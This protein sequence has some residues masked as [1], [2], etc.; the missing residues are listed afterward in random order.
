MAFFEGTQETTHEIDYS[1]NC[2]ITLN[3]AGFARADEVI[4]RGHVGF[5]IVAK[6]T[7]PVVMRQCRS[8][9]HG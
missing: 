8:I 1:R 7:R 6:D 4:V 9:A 3:L 5:Q 2:I